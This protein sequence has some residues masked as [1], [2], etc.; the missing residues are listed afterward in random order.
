MNYR[1]K[2]PHTASVTHQ[3]RNGRLNA[4]SVKT[5]SAPIVDLVIANAPYSGK[6][7]EIASGTGQHIV[8][9]ATAVPN[10]DWQPTDVDETRLKSIKAWSNDE[11]LVNLRPPCFLDATEIGWSTSHHGYN[12]LLVINLMHLISHKEAVILIDE[13]SKSIAP[14][15]RAIIYGP[16]MR[17]GKLTSAGDT[18]FHQSLT[19]ADPDLGYKNDNEIIELFRERGLDNLIVKNMPANNLAFVFEKH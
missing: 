8:T 6:A 16:F 5:N 15:G 9:L 12:F 1:K 14:K 17:N 11:N 19:N 7:L 18:D 3:D 4:P 2:L 13:I 10:L